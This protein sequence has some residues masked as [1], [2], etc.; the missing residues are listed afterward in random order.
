MIPLL[1]FLCIISTLS[2]GTLIYMARQQQHLILEVKAQPIRRQRLEIYRAIMNMLNQIMRDNTIN[3]DDLV[4][5]KIATGEAKLC[6][7]A[8]IMDYIETLYDK[9]LELAKY[10]EDLY[11][12]HALPPGGPR[13]HA[14][15]EAH[16]ISNWFIHEIPKVH[17][18][19]R[20]YLTPNPHAH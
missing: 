10:D 20:D 9:G 14:S 17:N 4:E 16:Y 7:S 19:F 15:N 11:S 2:A 18:L 6:C 13:D 5:F 1:A 8:E 12:D 3:F